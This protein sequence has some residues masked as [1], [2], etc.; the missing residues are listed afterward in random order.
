MRKHLDVPNV[1]TQH[2]QQ[3]ALLEKNV[4]KQVFVL[5][6]QEATIAKWKD[7]NAILQVALVS[8]NV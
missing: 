5:V 6:A 7:K 3:R 4:M 8:H 2:R 1:I